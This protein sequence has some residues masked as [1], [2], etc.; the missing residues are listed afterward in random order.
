MLLSA[1]VFWGA[2]TIVAAV[3]VTVFAIVMALLDRYTEHRKN[4]EAAT[5]EAY[6]N[7]KDRLRRPSSPDS[8]SRWN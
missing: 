7:G 5:E 6:K 8:T 1:L 2:L 3:I 4:L